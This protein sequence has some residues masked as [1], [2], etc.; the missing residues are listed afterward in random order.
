M[1]QAKYI[2]KF[3]DKHNNIIGYKLLD[4]HGNIK[5]VPSDKLK[6][7]IKNKNI[8]VINLTLTSDNRLID[9]IYCSFFKR[10]I[11]ANI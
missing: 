8:D 1:I 10:N 3:R 6:I 4:S 9:K 11:I 5:D 7:A 2:Q